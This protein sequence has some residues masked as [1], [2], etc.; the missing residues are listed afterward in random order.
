MPQPSYPYACARISAL[1]K[2]LLRAQTVHRMLE[3]SL[4]DVMR[5]LLDARYGNM[6]DATAEDGE[7]MIE[8][9]RRRTASI[10]RELSPD[11][12]LTDLFL[13]QTDAHNL[14]SLVKAR[15]LGTSEIVYLEGG[16][17]ARDRL[18]QMVAEQRYDELPAELNDALNALESK[19]RIRTEPQMVSVLIDGGYLA[20]CLAVAET[21][22][23]PFVKQYFAALCD[24]D[25]VITFL[26]MRAMGAPKEE[27]DDVLLPSGGIGKEAL[28]NAFEFS[29]D[30]LLR[31]LSG[32]VAKDA[33]L[34]GLNAMLS[35]GNIADLEKE[36][37]D[38]LLSLVN[39]R[40]HDALSIF[41]IVG[42]YLARDREARA[43]RLI[44][45]AKRNGL[46]ESVIAERLRALYG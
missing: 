13:L 20:H 12:T 11:P 35:S 27:L 16:L 2:G 9:E 24:F 32:S 36:R 30:S 6:P 7:R 38:Y 25:N 31:A 43:V 46:D 10:I 15:L 39:A 1:E 22:K 45:T 40:R 5:Q 26:R 34:K 29:S 18:S 37:D 4:D 23:E 42:Y 3:G 41:P 44:L 8:N 33:L 28:I 14:K 17:Y 21:C 19:L